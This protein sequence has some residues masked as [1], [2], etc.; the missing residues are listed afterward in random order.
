[1]SEEKI[2]AAKCGEC[3]L[4]KNNCGRV[5]ADYITELEQQ[6]QTAK[7]ENE[8]LNK[9]LD[10]YLKLGQS[11]LD[12]YKI[13][14]EHITQQNKQMREALKKV[15]KDACCSNGDC[16]HCEYDEDCFGYDAQQ[17]LNEVNNEK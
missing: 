9:K 13:D 12:D 16:E 17:A 4:D 6:L 14:I 2:R 7:E 10:E 8:K 15:K 3:G 1:M 5:C 11:I